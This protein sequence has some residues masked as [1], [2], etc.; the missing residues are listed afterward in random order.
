MKI[1]SKICTKCKEEKPLSNFY[2]KKSRN[3]YESNCKECC[4]K[5]AKVWAES[6]SKRVS[7]NQKAWKAKNREKK[8]KYDRDRY[9]KDRE[10]F[11]KKSPEEKRIRKNT[12]NRDT[13]KENKS[14][15]LKKVLSRSIRGALKS[16][17]AGD[18][19]L[20]YLPYT[21]QELK[22]HLESQFETWMNWD[23]WGIYD[24]NTWNDDDSTTWKW[25]I[26]HIVPHSSFKY[27]SMKDEEF[28]K[29]WDLSNLRPLSAKENLLKGNKLLDDE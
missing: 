9:W 27:S 11:V 16:P 2:F 19:I 3:V 23:N 24:S 8:L 5:R 15:R 26:D 22:Q 18:S 25:Q 10:P 29:C 17:K 14:H 12:Y 20:K 28:K 4:V 1:G 13:Y 21:I 7:D 6:N